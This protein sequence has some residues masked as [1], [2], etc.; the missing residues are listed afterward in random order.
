M[1]GLFKKKMRFKSGEYWENRYRS[2]GNSGAGSYNNLALFKAE[3]INELISAHNFSS[4][5]EFGCGDG[6]QLSL[7]NTPRYTG[8]DVSS[9]AIQLCRQKFANDD[10]KSFFL[11]DSK[12][13]IDKQGLFRMDVAMSLDVLFHLVEKEIYEIYLEHLFSCA[14][15][16]VIIYAADM[17]L[18]HPTP[19]EAYRKF[20]RDIQQRFS[21]WKLEKYIKNKYPAKNYEDQEG[22]LA[23][24]FIY[25]PV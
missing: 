13:F 14:S 18:E 19:H 20:T 2:G 10:S 7:L 25:T 24:F 11:Y 5:I 22:S 17:D 3:V 1:P 15:K 16:M 21:G 23:D 4:M 8:L 6:N 9:G 12:C